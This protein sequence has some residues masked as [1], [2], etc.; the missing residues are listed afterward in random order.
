MGCL[1][2]ASVIFLEATG[3]NLTT[4]IFLIV[5]ALLL[6]VSIGGYIV[7]LRQGNKT[8]EPDRES[9]TGDL[10]RMRKEPASGALEVVIAGQTFR[11]E[12]EMSAVQRTLAG[13]ALNDLR[14]WL[15]PQAT[16]GQTAESPAEAV[17]ATTAV[18]ATAVSAAA[19]AVVA[20]EAD[21]STAKTVSETPSGQPLETPSDQ[22]NLLDQ[23]NDIPAEIAETEE[24]KKRKRGGLIGVFTRAISSDVP[25]P[26][27]VTVSI[28]VQV[29][30]ILQNKLKGTPLESRGVCLME[31]PGQEMVVMIGTDQYDSVNAVPDDEIRAVLQSAVNEWLARSTT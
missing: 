8:A 21:S 10:I 23:Q 13:Y 11:S 5:C 7:T 2:Q 22:P 30:T 3:M 17:V 26:R 18:S 12:A 14:S 1:F 31:L 24:P 6:G 27:I 28:A 9:R 4:S 19:A 16:S 15:S 29:N 25:S 20:T